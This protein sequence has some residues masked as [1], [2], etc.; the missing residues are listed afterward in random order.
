MYI[1]TI[2][3]NKEGEKLPDIITGYVSWAK[4]ITTTVNAYE[5]KILIW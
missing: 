5:P 2:K 1:L 3:R 4:Y